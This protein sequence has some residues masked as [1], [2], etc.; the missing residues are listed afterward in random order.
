MPYGGGYDDLSPKN[1]RLNQY[2]FIRKSKKGAILVEFAFAVPILFS[3]V[4]YIYDLSKMKRIQSQISFMSNIMVNV[5]QNVSQNRINKRI[6][7]KDLNYARYLAGLVYFPGL[8]HYCTETNEL[9]LG[10][11]IVFFVYYV[12]GTAHNKCKV[13]WRL[14][15]HSTAKSPD[16]SPPTLFDGDSDWSIVNSS[17][18]ELSSSSVYKSLTIEKDEVK[19]LLELHFNALP[20]YIASNGKPWGNVSLSQRFGLF[21]ISPKSCSKSSSI[22]SYFNTVTIFTPKPGLFSETA[23]AKD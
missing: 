5:I 16:N 10:I 21:L 18:G 9:P 6:T 22:Y 15:G 12:K 8:S 17:N 20:S 14:D 2:N 19:I 23:P 1:N 13:I 7:Q 4:L 3:L 11:C